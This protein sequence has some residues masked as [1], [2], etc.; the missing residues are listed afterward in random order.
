VR[1]SVDCSPTESGFRL[2]F[3]GDRESVALVVAA[4]EAE[5]ACCRFLRFTLRFEQ[6][7]GPI[8]LELDGPE[9][10]RAFLAALF[11]PAGEPGGV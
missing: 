8:V 3:S 7:L 10:T 5:R 1:K 6:D 2:V 9:G 4:I 11:T